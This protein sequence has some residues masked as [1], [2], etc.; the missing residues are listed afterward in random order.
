MDSSMVQ[1]PQQTD[2]HL[3]DM[4]QVNPN[5]RLCV[6]FTVTH[7]TVIT[8]IQP[9]ATASKQEEV[10]IMVAPLYR[11]I[12]CWICRRCISQSSDF[13]NAEKTSSSSC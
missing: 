3:S 9:Y 12:L 5:V 2:L 6:E 4:L 11:D 13:I 10:N 7:F 1:M 8:T